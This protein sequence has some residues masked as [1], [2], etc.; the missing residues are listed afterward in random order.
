M[1]AGHAANMAT[2]FEGDELEPDWE[3]AKEHYAQGLRKAVIKEYELAGKPLPHPQVLAT[4]I[5]NEAE[6]ALRAAYNG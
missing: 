1:S 4:I 5:E 2:L 3:Y 6:R